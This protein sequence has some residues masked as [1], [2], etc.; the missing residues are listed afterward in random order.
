LLAIQAGT[1]HSSNI[2]GAITSTA[3]VSPY[4]RIGCDISIREIAAEVGFS[5]ATIQRYW[6]MVAPF[7]EGVS[8]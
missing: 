4:D 6:V 7:T 1:H 3:G 8:D 2:D 5:K